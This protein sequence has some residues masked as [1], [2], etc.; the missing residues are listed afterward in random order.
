MPE[1]SA[2]ISLLVQHNSG[3]PEKINHI[4]KVCG[5]AR[6]IAREEGLSESTILTVEIAAA[7]CNIADN[8]TES[9]MVSDMLLLNLGYERNFIEKVHDLVL[10]NASYDDITGIDYQ[11]LAEANFLVSAFENRLDKESIT[12]V[13]NT[14]FKTKCGKQYLCDMYGVSQEEN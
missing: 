1:L 10:K 6:A 4:M 11:I 14:V 8:G 13:L 5:F 2:L 7:V 3:E 12:E 9:A